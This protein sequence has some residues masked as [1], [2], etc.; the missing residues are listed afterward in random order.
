[1]NVCSLMNSIFHTPFLTHTNLKL[2]MLG[3][4]ESTHM[5]ALCK[6]SIFSGFSDLYPTP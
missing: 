5:K 3:K 4:A 6:S 1:M 2:C